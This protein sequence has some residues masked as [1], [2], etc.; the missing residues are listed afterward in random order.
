MPDQMAAYLYVADAEDDRAQPDN[1]FFRAT[2][3]ASALSLCKIFA[4]AYPAQKNR[5]RSDAAAAIPLER[6]ILLD[7]ALAGLGVYD[8][9]DPGIY[10]P[11]PARATLQRAEWARRVRGWECQLPNAGSARA[12]VSRT[13]SLQSSTALDESLAKLLGALEWHR[14]L[15]LF[16]A[17]A[18]RRNPHAIS[19][20]GRGMETVEREEI[21][22]WKRM[23][24]EADQNENFLWDN[25]HVI[26]RYADAAVEAF[27][28][29]DGLSPSE[30]D[31]T[32][33]RV[34][35]T[36][37]TL[38]YWS[39][40]KWSVPQLEES[41]DGILTACRGVA[42]ADDHSQLPE[43][44][45]TCMHLARPEDQSK[46]TSSLVVRWN[47]LARLDAQIGRIKEARVAIALR[48]TVPNSAF[49]A[50]NSPTLDAQQI[51]DLVVLCTVGRDLLCTRRAYPDAVPPSE[52][53][54]LLDDLMAATQRLLSLPGLEKFQ[55]MMNAPAV[56]DSKPSDRFAMMMAA[57]IM[58]HPLLEKR[59][60]SL[61]EGCRAIT[62]TM[63]HCQA[64]ASPEVAGFVSRLANMMVLACRHPT[65]PDVN[66]F[67]EPARFRQMLSV[68]WNVARELVQTQAHANVG[69]SPHPLLP[70]IENLR[71]RIATCF[72]NLAEMM[73]AR[74]SARS[75]D[76]LL[77]V[78]TE[79]EAGDLSAVP[80]WADREVQK[81]DRF[82]AQAGLRLGARVFHLTA[83][84]EYF[85]KLVAGLADAHKKR[86][87]DAGRRLLPTRRPSAATAQA[88]QDAASNQ[89]VPTPAAVPAV[90]LGRLGEPCFVRG[91]EK[92]CLTRTQHKTIERLLAAGEN[93]LSLNELLYKN[94][95][96]RNSLSKLRKDPDWAAVIRMAGKADGGYRILS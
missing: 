83:A 54:G 88:E 45:R 31:S 72:S 30:P 58:A 20:F 49:P 24:E 67:K 89:V 43:L 79:G 78:L 36:D 28:P 19:S 42:V 90:V 39:L 35:V 27:G 3:V 63:N 69:F 10:D 21:L 9:P 80:E 6:Q 18:C 50:L 41:S 65:A 91:K 87:N 77:A 55:A 11:P 2:S 48:S 1:V 46:W 96:G 5:I 32:G 60:E 25:R 23:M 61:E 64:S 14:L 68:Y 59:P 8:D 93:G 4:S 76:E 34:P 12:T 56:A 17:D 95:G 26:D 82:I 57:A 51:G 66:E 81:I 16:S 94:P 47:Y 7:E 40:H 86:V 29:G 22:G 71:D 75:C 92:P 13:P 37:G 15:F 85:I 38:P 52:Y 33:N 74:D 84:E 73:D 53:Q 62:E 70:L 44:V